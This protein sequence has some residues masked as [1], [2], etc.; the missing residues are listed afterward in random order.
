M[1][2]GLPR[3]ALDGHYVKLSSRIYLF[4]YLNVV[5]LIFIPEGQVNWCATM[6][7]LE[8]PESRHQKY[9]L[10]SRGCGKKPSSVH[11]KSAIEKF[12]H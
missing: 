4:I 11:L 7:R 3:L 2:Q 1:V 9:F 6:P 8:G 10:Q 12:I 5:Q